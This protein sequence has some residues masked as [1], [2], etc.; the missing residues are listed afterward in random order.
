MSDTGSADIGGDGGSGFF[1]GGLFAQNTGTLPDVTVRPTPSNSENPLLTNPGNTDLQGRPLFGPDTTNIPG[2][3]QGDLPG[4]GAI[5]P[6]TGNPFNPG[7]GEGTG[8]PGALGDP[9]GGAATGGGGLGT[10][11]G[12]GGTTQAMNWLEELAIRIMLLIVGLV[13]IAGGFH[14][15]AARGIFSGLPVASIRRTLQ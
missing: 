6:F 2:V 14:I 15:A 1:S 4:G 5:D 3:L 7:T 8:Q 12:G 13:L 9:T 10:L 11:L